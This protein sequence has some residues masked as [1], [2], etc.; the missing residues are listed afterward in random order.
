MDKKMIITFAGTKADLHKE[1]K[2]WSAES[3]TTMHGNVLK[4][5]EEGLKREKKAD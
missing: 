2:K 5:I 1:L 4:Y 3:E